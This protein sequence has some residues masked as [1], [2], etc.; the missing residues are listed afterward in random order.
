M[1]SYV[2]RFESTLDLEGSN[3]YS[4]PTQR[5]SQAFDTQDDI[6]AALLPSPQDLGL[7][8]RHNSL[9]RN[10]RRSLQNYRRYIEN[11]AMFGDNQRPSSVQPPFT[12]DN[13]SNFKGQGMGMFPYQEH[14]QRQLHTH[15]QNYSF[16][17]PHHFHHHRHHEDKSPTTETHKGFPCYPN[18]TVSEHVHHDTNMYQKNLKLY[19]ADAMY[20]GDKK[21]LDLHYKHTQTLKIEKHT[22]SE[23][24]PD[25]K[26]KTASSSPFDSG[27]SSPSSATERSWPSRSPQNVPSS[28]SMGNLQCHQAPS[29]SPSNVDIV[30]YGHFQ[31]YWEETKPYE[32]SDFYKYSTKHRKQHQAASQN[33]HAKLTAW[34]ANQTNS[35]YI[36]AIPPI[37]SPVLER[38]RTASPASSITG[39]NNHQ[40]LGD[41]DEK[42]SHCLK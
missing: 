37:M 42:S 30:T 36:S 22:W 3:L 32:T 21:H 24:T 40:K 11:A 29:H 10:R 33:L 4:V 5:T 7:M 25:T 6:L 23:F 27:L 34:K 1:D 38:S 39:N 18:Q 12:Y 17:H 14:Q 19:A 20:V 13:I 31:P 16:H 35:Q 28:S 15:V 2:N 9:D 41:G 8:S 26:S